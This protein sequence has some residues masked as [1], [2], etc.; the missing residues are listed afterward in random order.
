MKMSSVMYTIAKHKQAILLHDHC[1]LHGCMMLTIAYCLLFVVKNF[2]VFGGLLCNCKSFLAN[3]CTWILW[4]LVKAGDRECFLWN[5][6]KDV[7][8][9]KFF[10]CKWYK[11]YT[12]SVW[13]SCTCTINSVNT[14]YGKSSNVQVLHK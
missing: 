7:K 6:G 14:I 5:E 9:R 2:H 8:Q 13:D 4:K 3:F 1:I 12:V 10:H 11:Q